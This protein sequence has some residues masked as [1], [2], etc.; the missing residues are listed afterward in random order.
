V[1]TAS[2]LSAFVAYLLPVIGWIYVFVFRRKDRFAIFHAKQAVMLVVAAIAALVVWGVAAWLVVRV[3]I[4]GPMAAAGTFAL[5][6][7]AFLLLLVAW[8]VGMANALRGQ[9]KL[10]PLVGRW[11]VQYLGD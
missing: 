6:V 2:R 7:A 5:V 4:L 11:A 1:K 9:V 3:P 8:I 10:L